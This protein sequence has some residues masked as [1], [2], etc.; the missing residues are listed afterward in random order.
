[1][2]TMF[3]L[4]R[5]DLLSVS[6]LAGLF[7]ARADPG[8]GL[9]RRIGAMA[10]GACFLEVADIAATLAAGNV[11]LAI[12][13]LA[14]WAFL[15]GMISS[16]GSIGTRL[17]ALTVV[18][19]IMFGSTTSTV[20][21]VSLGCSAILISAATAIAIKLAT[22]LFRPH[23]SID[24]NAAGYYLALASCSAL[25]RSTPCDSTDSD[26]EEDRFWG[27]VVAAQRLRDISY[28]M[29]RNRSNPSAARARPLLGN[30]DDLSIVRAAVQECSRLPSLKGS[31]SSLEAID[32]ALLAEDTVLRAIAFAIRG[33][34]RPGK[35]RAMRKALDKLTESDQ[36]LSAMHTGGE[37]TDATDDFLLV[38]RLL[39]QG[40]AILRK[41]VVGMA[42][43]G[44][45]PSK[46]DHGARKKR[47]SLVESIRPLADQLTLESPI[48]RHSL[49][50]CV[51]LLVASIIS[52][53]FRIPH[54]YWM[55]L[56]AAI[57]LKPDFHASRQRAMQRVGGTVG[58]AVV[59]FI[60][61]ALIHDSAILLLP[62]VVL[63]FL[64]FA[65][66]SK[67]Y[68]VYSLFWT[69]AIILM[70][71]QSNGGS[72]A[73]ALERIVITFAGG[74]LGLCALYFFLPQWEKAS[75]P[76]RIAGMLSSVRYFFLAI[77]AAYSGRPIPSTDFERLRLNAYR[78]CVRTTAAMR[79]FSKNPPSQRDGFGRYH[80]IVSHG[81]R[82][83]ATLAILSAHRPISDESRYPSEI[84][85]ILGKLAERMPILESASDSGDGLSSARD[86]IATR[87]DELIAR[88]GNSI[89]HKAKSARAPLGQCIKAIAT[90]IEAL[91]RQADA[92]SIDPMSEI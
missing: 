4:H 66:Q 79:R 46:R 23:Q 64:A 29:I 8:G 80:D 76:D 67:N 72:L 86:T 2:I 18:A 40:S 44:N 51:S 49:R 81:R 36:A 52:T 47:W 34:N 83:F 17:G 75:L 78:E 15:A 41:A 48:F 73:I 58:G 1:M 85:L 10:L 43:G 37:N 88:E 77:V 21:T 7:T 60:V 24:D 19:L 25:G 90:N 14:A 87:I 63:V 35:T 82:L 13:G 9:G 33:A 5:R 22:I 42:T 6:M 61:L 55:P 26:H 74:L 28:L 70:L 69:S 84:A 3:L 65:S 91:T 16:L 57:V 62:L 32:R 45:N 27:D 30:A 54:G 56:T 39:E 59:S 53:A 20:P 50:L 38:H 12:G 89:L 71:D 68:G 11:A 92:F 31:P